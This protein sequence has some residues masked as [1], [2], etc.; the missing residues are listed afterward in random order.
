MWPRQLLN[1]EPIYLKIETRNKLQRWRTN[2]L[3]KWQEN[4]KGKYKQSS[5]AAAYLKSLKPYFMVEDGELLSLG[6][7]S[8]CCAVWN[9]HLE[10]L[11]WLRSQGCP[12]DDRTCSY[13]ALNGHL[14]EARAIPGWDSYTSSRSASRGHL[15]VLQCAKSQGC[16][17]D[18]KMFLQ[19]LLLKVNWMCCSGPGARAVPTCF[20]AAESSHLI[21]LQWL[22]S[23]G[24]PWGSEIC[25]VRCSVKKV[26]WKFC[27]G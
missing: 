26:T 11:Q 5:D 10:L 14:N 25:S 21:V 27:N 4:L 22:R 1:W 16:P 13:A 24:C 23:Q 6:K 3:E 20:G 7:W 18:R 8:C 2:V 17:C 9:G 19:Q 12:W 15:N